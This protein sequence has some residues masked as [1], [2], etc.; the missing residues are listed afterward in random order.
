M[1]KKGRLDGPKVFDYIP[2]TE[3]KKK[4]EENKKKEGK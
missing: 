2:P 3:V 4:R 1:K